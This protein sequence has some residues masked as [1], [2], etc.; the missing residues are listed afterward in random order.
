M[1]LNNIRT[2]GFTLVEMLVY[3]VTMV[4]VLA[5]LTYFVSQVYGYYTS[6][7][8]ESRV[9][10]AASTLSQVLASEMRSGVSIDQAHTTFGVADGMLTINAREDTTPVIKAFSIENDRV[11]F[12]D[13]S[14][15]YFLT[16]EDMFVS[17]FLFTQIVT[18]VS[19]AIRYEIDITFE[20]EG[21]LTTK[22]YPGVVTLRHSYE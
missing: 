2:K 12:E 13:G 19:Y 6:M 9:D 14:E 10:R 15:T 17:K 5:A 18:P 11:R 3:V 4:L 16:P 7:T 20:K 1:T 8:I 22:T 21:T